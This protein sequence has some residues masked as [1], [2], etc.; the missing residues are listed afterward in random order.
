MALIELARFYNSFEAGIVQSRLEADG[1]PCVLFDVEMSL[2]AMGMA[3]PI[4]LM[5]DDEDEAEARAIL[6][7]A[8]RGDGA[9]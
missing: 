5:I 9:A 6:A 3:I 1:I 8:A 7:E 4:R 2:Q